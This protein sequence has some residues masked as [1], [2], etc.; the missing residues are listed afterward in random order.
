MK[1]LFALLLAL[2][3]VLS[4]AAC[5]GDKDPT[6]SGSEDNTPSNRQ[7]PS[8]NDDGGEPALSGEDWQKMLTRDYGLTDI[9]NPGGTCDYTLADAS[10]MEMM[11]IE[12]VS[13]GFDFDA[14]AEAVWNSCK[15]TAKDGQMYGALGYQ[16][17]NGKNVYVPEKPVESYTEA[18]DTSG[19]Y[20]W[21]YLWDGGYEGY[22][23][24][25]VKL[26]WIESD[27]MLLLYVESRETE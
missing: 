5:G 12:E 2:V 1:K 13:D 22:G 9:P 26:S 10:S 11:F 24:K 19:D 18:K 20:D 3:M 23:C 7:Q 27:R 17:V 15:K 4:L 6:P 8:N 16:S 21:L 14:F 25:E